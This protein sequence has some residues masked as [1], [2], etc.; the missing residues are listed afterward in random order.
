MS[1][2][3]KTASEKEHDDVVAY[4]CSNNAAKFNVLN[5]LGIEKNHVSGLYPDIIIKNKTDE[6]IYRFIIE[7]K[8]NGG[9][10]SCLQQWKNTTNIPCVL[11][12]IVPETDLPN[13]IKIA[14]TIGIQVKFGS[15][16]I[17]QSVISVK[18]E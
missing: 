17:E 8:K 1:T 5:N 9:I 13:A 10:A 4:I 3:E 7:V 12:I 18:Y 11:Y 16:K 2:V 15:Y 6:D 14:G